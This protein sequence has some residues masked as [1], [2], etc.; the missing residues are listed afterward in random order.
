MFERCKNREKVN[1]AMAPIEIVS[2]N[3]LIL[4]AG[5]RPCTLEM[6]EI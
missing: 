4:D 2:F 1:I 5:R 3:N 6:Q